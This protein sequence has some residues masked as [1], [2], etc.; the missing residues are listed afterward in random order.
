VLD[1]RDKIYS[2]F[3][4]HKRYVTTQVETICATELSKVSI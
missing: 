1:N 3:F 2:A 4:D